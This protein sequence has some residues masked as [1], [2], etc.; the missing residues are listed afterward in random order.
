[1]E[2]SDYH[3]RIYAQRPELS[4]HRAKSH[5]DVTEAGRITDGNDPHGSDFLTALEIL[6]SL[7]PSGMPVALALSSLNLPS[8]DDCLR[9]E[10]IYR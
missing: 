3:P 1:M 7:R 10:T 8:A 4:A 5:R 2:Q 6:N 9:N